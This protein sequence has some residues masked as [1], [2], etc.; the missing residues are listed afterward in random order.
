M[1]NVFLP[2]LVLLAAGVIAGL[3]P[4]AGLPSNNMLT[5]TD[6]DGITDVIEL[7]MGLDLND[8]TDGLSDDDGDGLTLAEELKADT[9]PNEADSDHDDFEDL[10]EILAGT[11]P[12]DPNDKPH[13]KNGPVYPQPLQSKYSK[14][15]N[16][17]ANGV[18]I[19]T[20]KLKN[21]VVKGFHGKDADWANL[22]IVSGWSPIKGNTIETWSVEGERF[23]KI[24]YGITQ[25]I[26]K[27]LPGPYI[28]VW[29]HARAIDGVDA[30]YRITFVTDAGRVIASKVFSPTSAAAWQNA[31]L[32]FNFTKTDSAEGVRFKLEPLSDT[33]VNGFVDDLYM[34]R[35]GFNVDL[36]RDGHI[37]DTEIPEKNTPYYFWINNDTEINAAKGDDIPGPTRTT[38]DCNNDHVDT[39]RDLVDFFPVNLNINQL[40]RIYPPDGA[41]RYILRQK[42]SAVNL[43]H[44]S[45]VA[46]NT[47]WL[48]QQCG[49]KNF[50]D[51]L[52]Q[53][54]DAAKVHRL[55]PEYEL[56][57]EF[58]ESVISKTYSVILFEGNKCTKEPLIFS[59]ER[60]G[61]KLAEFELPLQLN[62][63]ETMYRQ[64]NLRDLATTYDGVR[65]PEQPNSFSQPTQTSE[66]KGL[67]DSQTQNKYFVF[68]HGFNVNGQEAR[69]WNSEMFKRFYVLGSQAR[70]VGVT[71]RSDTSPDYHEAVFRALLAGEGLTSRLGFTG[72]SP[73]TVAAHSLGNLVACNAIE[74][75]GLKPAAYLAINAAMPAEAF[76]AS[77]NSSTQAANMTESSWRTYD[78]YLYSRNWCKLFSS[79]D[80]R[81]RLTWCGQ[82]TKAAPYMYN[83]FSPGDDVLAKADSV[84][85]ASVISLL[86]RQGF[87]FSSNAW[88]FQELM[89]GLGWYSSGASFWVSRSQGG[90]EFNENWFYWGDDEEYLQVQYSPADALTIPLEYLRVKPFFS[91]FY[92]TEVFSA[93]PNIATAKAREPK[94]IYDLLARGLPAGSYAAAISYLSGNVGFNFDME[95]EGRESAYWPTAEHERSDQKK[96][97]LHSDFKNVALPVISRT[98]TSMINVGGL[99]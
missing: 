97:W 60:Q 53:P 6:G 23:T 67:P 55:T 61:V 92:A 68:I 22:A 16:F 37:E 77:Y 66:P 94:V 27:K 75:G 47:G 50:G 46:W 49:M 69:G 9:N 36:N 33:P 18:F 63:V 5:D 14:P 21:H 34:I 10:D 72:G 41:T 81:S 83:Y 45:V 8:P 87:N 91:P 19:S 11:D 12:T 17:L 38:S 76:N 31:Y 7:R 3:L 96:R 86:L 15:Y 64:L 73:I 90:W 43:V 32:A 48:N 57:A 84:K 85:S 95:Q 13:S 26:D 51:T 4:L 78:P 79:S 93:F 1:K 2:I 20:S 99:K 59:I 54:L 24:N 42:D 82:F 44:A 40:I 80:P 88:K 30:S 98:Y 58:L 35:A 56:P 62:E 74:R 65:L 29:K 28:L 52:N 25:R 89:K 70:F 39:L 71:W